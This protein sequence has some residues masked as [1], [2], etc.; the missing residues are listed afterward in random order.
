MAKQFFTLH[1]RLKCWEKQWKC[2]K[3]SIS[4]LLFFKLKYK[5]SIEILFNNI[6]WP[7]ICTNTF[8]SRIRCL[9]LPTSNLQKKVEAKFLSSS[10]FFFLT[11][12]RVT[13]TT[14][15]S[16]QSNATPAMPCK[17]FSNFTSQSSRD[18]EKVDLPFH[19]PVSQQSA[20]T[21]RHS[22]TGL[23]FYDH[24]EKDFRT[25]V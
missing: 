8:N 23:E 17:S 3:K 14:D 11:Q 4:L 6:Q 2:R 18:L 5:L 13:V 9:T 1:K 21:R 25:K 24:Q 15:K 19:T 16:I 7:L 12:S 10:S 20:K 22:W